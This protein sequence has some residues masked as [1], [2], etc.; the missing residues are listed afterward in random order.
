M[1]SLWPDGCQLRNLDAEPRDSP[2]FTG[3]PVGPSTHF[4]HTRSCLCALAS[5]PSEFLTPPAPLELGP[6]LPPA[7]PCHLRS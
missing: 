6:G 2:G 5:L 4:R 1:G 3:G 7:L